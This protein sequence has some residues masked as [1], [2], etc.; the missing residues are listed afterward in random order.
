MS[1]EEGEKKKKNQFHSDEDLEGI[2]WKHNLKRW[3]I[4]EGSTYFVLISWI[5]ANVIYFTYIV[6]YYQNSSNFSIRRRILGTTLLVARASA[7]CINLNVIFLILTVCRNLISVLRTT[8]LNYF[9]PFDKNIAFHKLIA[10]T[11]VFFVILHSCCHFINFLKLSEAQKPKQDSPESFAYTSGTT[12]LSLPLCN[13]NE[14]LT[15]PF[16]S[17]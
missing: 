5:L 13:N 2:R 16:S 11:T 15:R 3:L 14:C 6:V 7:G 12:T 17:T 9:I 8:R 10:G 4:N 1:K